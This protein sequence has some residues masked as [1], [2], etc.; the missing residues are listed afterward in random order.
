MV[1]GT[2]AASIVLPRWRNS[3]RL[4]ASNATRWQRKLTSRTCSPSSSGPDQHAGSR[5]QDRGETPDRCGEPRLCVC[6]P[7]GCLRR[8]GAGHA[9]LWARPSEVNCLPDAETNSTN[10]MFLS[11]FAALRDP[12]SRAYYVRK[13]S[14]GKRH[15]QAL[16]ALA[17]RRCDV[18]FAML[19]DGTLYKP[20]RP[21]KTVDNHIGAPP[22]GRAV[23]RRRSRG[24]RLRKTRELPRRSFIQR[25]RSRQAAA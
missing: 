10:A 9:A 11:A 17:R 15:N 25:R 3:L 19:R 20:T 24:P 23:Q 6:G 21:S 5:R 12:I 1:L 14:Q 16:I 7:S 2:Q 8:V 18:L 4:C 13:I 22:K